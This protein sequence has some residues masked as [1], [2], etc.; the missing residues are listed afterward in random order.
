[1]TIS[2]RTFRPLWG[3]LFI[4]CI[5]TTMS[6]KGNRLSVPSGDFS[7]FNLFLWF[8]KIPFS[9]FRPLWGFLFIQLLTLLCLLMSYIHFRPLWGFL[10]IQFGVETF[11]KESRKWASVP[12][13]DFSL[14]NWYNQK[15]VKGNTL[16]PSPLGISLYS[17]D[18]IK[19]KLRET[20][21]FRPLWGFLFIQLI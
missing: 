14:F 21:Y 17:I 19:N 2:N 12:S 3:F 10:F 11:N 6:N 7:L 4:Q 15:Q 9:Y 5:L 18:I 16:L 20:P 13:G 1:M 8:F